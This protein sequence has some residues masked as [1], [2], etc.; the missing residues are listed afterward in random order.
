[1]GE[2]FRNLP[3]FCVKFP[4]PSN[5]IMHLILIWFYAAKNWKRNNFMGSEWESK[6]FNNTRKLFLTFLT[7]VWVIHTNS[8]TIDEKGWLLYEYPAL[9]YLSLKLWYQQI[10]NLY[11]SNA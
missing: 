5:G 1:M 3:K 9:E 7:L 2:I 11:L 10:Q 8:S 4:K 6:I